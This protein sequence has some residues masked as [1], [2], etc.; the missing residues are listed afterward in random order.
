MMPPITRATT[1][2][3]IRIAALDVDTER[4]S[5]DSGDVARR[6]DQLFDWQLVAVRIASGPGKPG[7]GGSDR[8]GAKTFN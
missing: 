4:H 8:L 5:N 6:G 1:A 2:G 3:F 7:A